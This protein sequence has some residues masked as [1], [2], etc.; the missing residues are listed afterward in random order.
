MNLIEFEKLVAAAV[1]DLPQNIKNALD[2]VAIIIEP[3]ESRKLLGL[4]EGGQ[5][6]SPGRDRGQA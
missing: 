3:R 5:R 2:N 6:E 4:Y 1:D